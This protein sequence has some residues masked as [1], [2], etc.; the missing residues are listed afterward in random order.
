MARRCRLLGTARCWRS[1]AVAPQRSAVMSSAAATAAINAS[2]T[3][4]A[5]T[6][7]ARSARASPVPSG[8]RTAT[9]NCS[10]SP[11]STWC[12]PC[13]SR[14]PA[15][16]SRTR[17]WSMTS[18]SGPP[19]R[20]CVPSQPTSSIWGSRSASSRCCIPG[21]RT[22]CIIHICI[23]WCRV[24]GSHRTPELDPLPLRVL[25][26]GRGAVTDVSRSVPALSGEGICR[27]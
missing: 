15:S 11:T 8:W 22:C 10:T 2:P 26:A 20:R 17:P 6:G 12:S 9:R 3:T 19:R 21:D 27:G 25:P 23:A 7:T 1:N 24:A 5:V 4:P 13:R 16:R 18:C 14:S